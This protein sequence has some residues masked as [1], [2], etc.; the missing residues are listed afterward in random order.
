MF[1]SM[2]SASLCIKRPRSEALVFDQAPVSN[3]ARAASTALS[4][5]ALSA[6]ATLA[7]TSPVDGFVVS[8]V[9]PLAAFTHLPSIS[10]LVC[11]TL[12]CAAVFLPLLSFSLEL[13]FLA[14]LALERFAVAVAIGIL[15]HK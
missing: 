2:R 6:S 12:G 13:P 5:S 7:I 10:S 14:L 1:F 9:L 3:A 11:R 15:L 4:T 8:K